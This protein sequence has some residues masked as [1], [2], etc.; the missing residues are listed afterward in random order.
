MYKFNEGI[1]FKI[2]NITLFSF[3]SILLVNLPKEL[4][5]VVIIFISLLF[6]LVGISVLMFA[7]KISF[8]TNSKGLYWVRAILNIVGILSWL[9]ALKA[10]GVNDGAAIGYTTPIFTMLL[11]VFFCKE[12]FNLWCLLS[13]LLG[14][15]GSYIILS[16][17]IHDLSS[18][19]GAFL[20]VLSALTWA[21]YDILCKKQTST[22]HY[23]TQAFYNTLTTIIVILPLASYTAISRSIS[24]MTYSN[25]IIIIAII[26]LLSVTNK[27]FLFLA[28]SAAPVSVLMPFSYL[29]IIILSS[30]NYLIFNQAPQSTTLIGFLFISLASTLIFV[31][32]YSGKQLQFK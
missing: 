11:A 27:V 13:I 12:K 2:L 21:V 4:S 15:Y 26:G 23:L 24:I 7:L 5:T 10:I 22:E 32:Q 3:Y 30:L 14:F 1:L 16:P 25:N 9:E 28:Y 6:G 17:S 18:S 8:K 31:I 29:R 20:A 19:L